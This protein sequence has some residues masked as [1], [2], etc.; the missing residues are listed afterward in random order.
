[1]KM[2]HFKKMLSFIL[3]LIIVAAMTLLAVG[4]N[5]TSGEEIPTFT[6]TETKVL[7][8]GQTKFTF[9]CVDAKGN[10]AKFEISTDK[11]TVGA[12]LLEHKIIE[13][14]DSQYG[15]YVKTVNGVTLDYDKHKMYWAFYADG[16]YA[17][18]GV[19]ETEIKAGATYTYK[20]EK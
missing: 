3:C 16:A 1:M 6:S 10:E 11:Q 5:G 15:L 18:S 14:E 2:T 12:A 19:S 17:L 7:G 8:S 9:T 13:G 20:A 4:C